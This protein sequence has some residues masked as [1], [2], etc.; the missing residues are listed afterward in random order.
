MRNILSFHKIDY[1]KAI[2]AAIQACLN[3]NKACMSS[4][5]NKWHWWLSNVKLPADTSYFGYIPNIKSAGYNWQTNAH[6]E[7]STVDDQYRQWALYNDD[8]TVNKTYRQN[9]SFPRGRGHVGYWVHNWDQGWFPKTFTFPWVDWNTTVHWLSEWTAEIRSNGNTGAMVV[10]WVWGK[11]KYI[12]VFWQSFTNETS[13][14]MFSV[15]VFNSDTKTGTTLWNAFSGCWYSAGYRFIETK[16]TIRFYASSNWSWNYQ[17]WWYIDINKNAGT[18]WTY[19]SLWYQATQDFMNAHPNWEY[20]DLEWTTPYINLWTHSQWAF[21]NWQ[22]VWTGWYF[23]RGWDN[24]AQAYIYR[25]VD[26]VTSSGS[27]WGSWGSI[28]AEPL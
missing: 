11:W 23:Q 21:F 12:Y 20:E 5:A 26:L 10:L 9:S 14:P 6:Y 13:T 2:D 17:N 4:I 18:V 16:D 15:W 22:K 28:P 24:K 19:V 25:P 7:T 1:S 27:W 8:W 3:D